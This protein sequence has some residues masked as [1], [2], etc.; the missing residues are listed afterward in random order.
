LKEPN[1]NQ[2]EV[3]GTLLRMKKLFERRASSGRGGALIVPPKRPVKA[4]GVEFSGWREFVIGR[5]GEITG[6]GIFVSGD[7]TEVNGGGVPVSGLGTP[8]SGV[9]ARVVCE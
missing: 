8:V 3:G 6:A 2:G 9:G 5:G 7:G 4:G 1:P